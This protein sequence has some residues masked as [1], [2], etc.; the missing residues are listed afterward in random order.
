MKNKNN[1]KIKTQKMKNLVKG[2][3][4]FLVIVSGG[5]CSENKSHENAE[6][7]NLPQDIVLKDTTE[8]GET[9]IRLCT[10]LLPPPDPNL[11]ISYRSDTSV[12]YRNEMQCDT[13]ITNTFAPTKA[14]I[15]SLKGYYWEED[16]HDIKVTFLDGSITTQQR[17]METVKE[18]EK[19]CCIK[20]RFGNFADPDITI[21]FLYQGSW[22][23]I[24]TYSRKMRPSMNFG[25]LTD[26]SP[27]EEYNRV[28]LHEFGHALGYLHEH[29]NPNG[30]I[31]WD[32]EKV[33]NYYMRPPNNWDKPAVDRN[34]LMRYTV[35]QVNATAFD[36][37]SIMLYAIPAS[38]TLDGYSTSA[39]TALSEMD[40]KNVGE[41]YPQ[42]L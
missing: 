16:H 15:M 10:E 3:M 29:Q 17:V 27:Q 30:N 39:N 40:K 23:Y 14:Y 32:K 37:K 5:R 11:N 2:L 38:L 41:L 19:H 7:I 28:V 18:W 4:I 22:S 13:I 34:I 1:S 36:P 9:D 12:F 20:F 6:K 25:W 24:G 8:E 42:K 31:Q 35:N 26:N 33:Y 21:S